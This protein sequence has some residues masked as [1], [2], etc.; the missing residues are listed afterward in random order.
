VTNAFVIVQAIEA[1]S[2]EVELDLSSLNTVNTLIV[3][4]FRYFKDGISAILF[5]SILFASVCNVIYLWSK[6]GVPFKTTVSATVLVEAL[7]RSVGFLS[8]GQAN[9]YAGWLATS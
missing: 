7:N 4:V 6:L 2:Q 1:D 8:F 3:A 5:Y 9:L